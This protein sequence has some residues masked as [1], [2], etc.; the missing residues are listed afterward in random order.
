MSKRIFLL[1]AFALALPAPIL[2]APQTAPSQQAN[3]LLGEW[4]TPFGV[5]P[6]QRDQAGA[7]PAGD[8]GG[9]RR[10]SGRR[11]RR[12]SPNP[13]PPTFAN[14]IEALENAGELLA[15]VNAVFSG[16]QSAETNDQ[17]QAI[18]REVTP[19]QSALRD[20]IRLNAGLFARVK[21]VWDAAR[22]G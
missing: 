20:D 8:Q 10:S 17:L 1:L 14:T 5:P 12:S 18:N 4:T 11:S 15:R 21:A 22:R 19:L 2:T 13:Q 7:L 6:F 9:H 16:L 3:P